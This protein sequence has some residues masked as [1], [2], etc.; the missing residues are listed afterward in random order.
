MGFAFRPR[1]AG[2]RRASTTGP[3]DLFSLLQRL[4]LAGA[5]DLPLPLAFIFF[6]LSPYSVSPGVRALFPAYTRH[7]LS[8]GP[9]C[10]KPNLQ[11][12]I[13]KSCDGNQM[14]QQVETPVAGLSIGFYSG[15][16]SGNRLLRDL[17]HAVLF[18]AGLLFF[19]SVVRDLLQSNFRRYFRVSTDSARTNWMESHTKNP[20][21]LRI[22]F[23]FKYKQALSSSYSI[24][25]S[26]VND[27]SPRKALMTLVFRFRFSKLTRSA[28]MVQGLRSLDQFP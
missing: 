5:L 19:P 1:A 24:S 16:R 13:P 10:R 2:E 14:R 7:P 23:F 26:Q 6:S 25:V 17:S 3:P 22:F 15:S 12:Q 20:T 8:G 28:E 4:P 11:S 9:G 27:L 18:T 21:P